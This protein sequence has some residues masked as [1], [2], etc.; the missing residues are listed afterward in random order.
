MLKNKNI[1]IGV[2]A[3][4]AAYKAA[5]LVRSF[6]DKGANVKVI[7]TPFSEEFITKTTLSALS[8]HPVYSDFFKKEDGGWNSHVDLGSWADLL[9]IA[10]AT[11]NTIAKMVSGIADNLLLATYLSS[12]NTVFVAPAMD[13]KMFEHP[14]TQ[15]NIKALIKQ[16]IQIIE[17]ASGHLASGLKGKGR[18]QEPDV[19]V[20]KIEAYFSS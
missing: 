4:I 10:P 6:Q 1:L 16:G 17:P 3:S 14:A 5:I 9:I 18:M 12:R 8:G 19:I 11:A 13:A 7:M 15:Q 2:T 20:D